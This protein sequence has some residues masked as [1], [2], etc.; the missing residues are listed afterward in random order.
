MNNF[1][2]RKKP[3]TIKISAT[4]SMFVGCYLLYFLTNSFKPS[5]DFM[6]KRYWFQQARGKFNN[7]RILFVS[8]IS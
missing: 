5:R 7:I 4:V 8:T 3:P 1:V 2:S 6:T